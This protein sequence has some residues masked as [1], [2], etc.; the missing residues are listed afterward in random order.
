MSIT[1][2]YLLG[3]LGSPCL[4]QE[5][6]KARSEPVTPR[7]RLC[8]PLEVLCFS[9]SNVQTDSFV[10][11]V[12]RLSCFFSKLKSLSL[13][14]D[15]HL[16]REVERSLPQ[17]PALKELSIE[18]CL[19]GKESMCGLTTFFRAFPNLEKFVIKTLYPRKIVT[20]RDSDDVVNYPLQHLRV[21]EMSQYRGRSI[22]FELVKYFL[23]KM[24]FPLR[25][26]L[27]IHVLK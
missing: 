22:E 17:L 21:V 13:F 1:P 18:V 15:W 12:S 4:E 16:A 24:L 3:Y 23:K 10:N 27:L 11:D 9:S 2:L 7:P 25:R 20:H 5:S 6:S 14:L 8:G 26:L 19:A